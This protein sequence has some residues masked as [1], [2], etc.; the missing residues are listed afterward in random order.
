MTVVAALTGLGYPL[1]LLTGL[2]EFGCARGEFDGGDVRL[3]TAVRE[4]EV[5]AAADPIATS[6]WRTGQF[7]VEDW[8]DVAQ[9]AGLGHFAV[10][11][12]DLVDLYLAGYVGVPSVR[13]E[14]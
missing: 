7:C 5:Q 14:G 6:A 8:A 2:Q 10:G 11:A 13:S 1:T 4:S 9:G 3:A 12:G